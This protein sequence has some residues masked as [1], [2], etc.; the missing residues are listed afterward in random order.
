MYLSSVSYFWLSGLV[1]CGQEIAQE[2]THVDQNT[3]TAE[4][5]ISAERLR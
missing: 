2:C 1:P 5:R 4:I 3:A